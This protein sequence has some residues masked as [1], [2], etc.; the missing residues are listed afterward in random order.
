[1]CMSSAANGPWPSHPPIIYNL[2]PVKR[3]FNLNDEK[4]LTLMEIFGEV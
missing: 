4:N 1:M 2:L 3:E